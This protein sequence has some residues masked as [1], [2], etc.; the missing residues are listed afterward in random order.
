LQLKDLRSSEIL[1]IYESKFQDLAKTN[2]H[3]IS[4]LD[5]KTAALTQADSLIQEYRSKSLEMSGQFDEMRVLVQAAESRSETASAE[6]AKCTRLAATLQTEKAHQNAEAV[7]AAKELGTC[8]QELSELQGVK[9]AHTALLGLADDL[10]EQLG[11]RDDHCAAQNVR[12]DEMDGQL[13]EAG[14]L[15][16]ELKTAM[17]QLEQDAAMHA[18]VNIEVKGELSSVQTELQTVAE[19]RRVVADR[20]D[21]AEAALKARFSIFGPHCSAR[22]CHWIPHLPPGFKLTYIV[23]NKRIPLWRPFSNQLFHDSHH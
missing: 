22:K 23:Q 15:C 2:T 9:V 20:A 13:V 12:I 11:K 10:K 19:E 14:M 3:Q 21:T 18:A 1:S 5:A 8:K 17:L 7:A 6:S 4:L 16:H